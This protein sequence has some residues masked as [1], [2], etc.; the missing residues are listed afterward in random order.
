MPGLVHVIN[1]T[2]CTNT[3]PTYMVKTT[4]MLCCGHIEQKYEND[5]HTPNS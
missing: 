1:V 2:I 3:N 4:T 5:A